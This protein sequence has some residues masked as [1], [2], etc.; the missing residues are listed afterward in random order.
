MAEHLS[1]QFRITGTAAPHNYEREEKQMEP[2][3]KGR[4]ISLRHSGHGH[5]FILIPD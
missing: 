4:L 3:T 5:G 1:L 2:V